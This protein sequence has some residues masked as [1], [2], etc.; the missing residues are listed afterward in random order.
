M[1]AMTV[2]THRPSRRTRSRKVVSTAG[3]RAMQMAALA[4]TDAV[5]A[6]IGDDALAERERLRLEDQARRSAQGALPLAAAPSPGE[7]A[8]ARARVRDSVAPPGIEARS[9]S[10]VD[11]SSLDTPVAG[12]SDPASCVDSGRGS[13]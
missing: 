4:L 2:Y 7:V 12:N 11:G 3:L 6:L 8:D 5:P 1:M 13:Y 9:G 10:P